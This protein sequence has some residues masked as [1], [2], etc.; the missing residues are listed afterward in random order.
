M[1]REGRRVS[2]SVQWLDP[3]PRVLTVEGQSSLSAVRPL[4]EALLQAEAGGEASPGSTWVLVRSVPHGVGAPRFHLFQTTELRQLLT[5]PQFPEEHPLSH[6]LYL[7]DCPESLTVRGTR[8]HHVDPPDGPSFSS[9][10]RVVHFDAHGRL[11]SIGEWGRLGAG[12]QAQ[13]LEGLAAEGDQAQELEGSAPE[14]HQAQQLEGSAPEETQGQQLEGAPSE[15]SQTQQ[16]QRGAPDEAL[17]DEWEAASAPPSD[18]PRIELFGVTGPAE[19]QEPEGFEAVLSADAPEELEVG[20]SDFVEFRIERAGSEARPLASSVPSPVRVREGMGLRILLSVRGRAVRV[21]G[22]RLREVEPPAPGRATVGEFEVEAVE[23]GVAE[24]ALSFRQ[25]SGELGAIRF[26]LEVVE[27]GDR[28]ALARQEVALEAVPAEAGEERLLRL[29]IEE[30]S[31]VIES[32]GRPLRTTFFRY[33]LV[34]EELGLHYLTLDSRPLLNR[35]GTEA[36]DLDGYVD[37][38]YE[39][40]TQ[41]LRRRSD[42]P[43]FQEELRAVGVSLASELLSPEVTRRLWPL[44]DR[45]EGIQVTSWEPRIPWE[46]LRLRHPDTGEVDARTFA[47]YSLVRTFHG[48]LPPRTLPLERWRYLAATYPHGTEVS[49]RTEIDF[50]TRTLPQAGVESEAIDPGFDALWATLQSGNFDVL[51]LACHGLADPQDIRRAALIIGDRPGPGPDDPPEPIVLDAETV[52][53]G[54]RLHARRPVVFL[55]ACEAGRHGI[56]LTA[57]GGWPQTF[58]E[59]GAGVFVGASWPVRDVP[60]QTFAT[61]FYEAL[62]EGRT[63][64]EAAQAAR[65]KTKPLGDASW[66]AFKVYGH[67]QARRGLRSTLPAGSG[68]SVGG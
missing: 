41:E 35:E 26:S 60:A 44:R 9:A 16:W 65:E 20:S 17:A 11:R 14:E 10:F 15:G 40:V 33:R 18:S 37:W 24:I 39:R 67:P 61:A 32:G 7:E 52:R 56:G 46:L 64:R 34:S 38:I 45:I 43:R 59:A 23:P 28:S 12:P 54:V 42:L 57:W 4:L 2:V 19:D 25:G 29:L 51:H 58:M 36:R 21:L 6:H 3:L 8:P 62:W 27:A 13:Q 66:L 53:Y 48:E 50:L 49:V 68:A 22:P 47:E 63:L 55:H 30:V 5:D 1:T 31:E